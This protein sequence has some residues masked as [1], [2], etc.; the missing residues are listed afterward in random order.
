MA[1]GGRRTWPASSWEQIQAPLAAANLLPTA[2]ADDA[3]TKPEPVQDLRDVIA[4]GMGW[5]V[6]WPH[7]DGRFAQLYHTLPGSTITD[8]ADDD[9]ADEN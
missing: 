6:E 9:V 2:T 8:L 4:N 7:I 1:T 5:Y 3:E